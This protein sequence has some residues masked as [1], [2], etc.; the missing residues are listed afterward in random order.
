M[1]EGGPVLS[2]GIFRANEC[3]RWSLHVRGG[4][5]EHDE[6]RGDGVRGG[7][8]LQKWGEKDMPGRNLRGEEG[9]DGRKVRRNVPGGKYVSGGERCAHNVR[10]GGV[11]QCWGLDVQQLRCG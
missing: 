11:Q 1:R 4:R 7:L 5:E 9:N 6:G 3:Y 10:D 2:A 8:L